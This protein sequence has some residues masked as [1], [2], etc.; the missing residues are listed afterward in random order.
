[1]GLWEGTKL[2]PNRLHFSWENI[3]RKK[4]KEHTDKRVLTVQYKECYWC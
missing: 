3:Q 1:M 4:P 2:D